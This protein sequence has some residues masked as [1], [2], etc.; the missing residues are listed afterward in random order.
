LMLIIAMV[1]T[2]KKN[3][4]LLALTLP[5]FSFFVSA[6]PVL[7][8]MLLIA[9]ELSANVFL[10]YLLRRAIKYVFPSMLLS[11]A[12]SKALYYI[13]K[14]CLIKLAVLHMEFLATPLAAQVITT[15]LFSFY[16]YVFYKN[17]MPRRR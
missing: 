8:K 14:F 3:A 6:H 2:G 7:P 12:L 4:L 10:F 15:L 9:M 16:A 11:I 17:E 13:M 5:V 1:H